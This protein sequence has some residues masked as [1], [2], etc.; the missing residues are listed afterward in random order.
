MPGVARDDRTEAVRCANAGEDKPRPYGAAHR[1]KNLAQLYR[2]GVLKNASEA[3][4]QT[5]EP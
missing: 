5:D 3:S 1:A 2:W 4:P